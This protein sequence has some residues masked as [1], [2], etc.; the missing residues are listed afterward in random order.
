MLVVLLIAI[1]L[2]LIHFEG[3]VVTPS[4]HF[5]QAVRHLRYKVNK[6]RFLP[7]HLQLEMT[8]Y[9]YAPRT[10][11]STLSAPRLSANGCVFRGLVLFHITNNHQP[12]FPSPTEVIAHSKDFEK[13]PQPKP[14]I[15]PHLNLLVKFEHHAQVVVEEALFLRA[16]RTSLAN[17]I[18]SPEVYGWRAHENIVFIYMKLIQG[19]TLRERWDTLTTAQKTA[20]TD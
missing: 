1:A 17:K 10:R 12:V 20:I 4:N 14:V 13:H 18:P 9:Q 3:H 16:L 19:D 6:A 8:V 7:H 5:N 2:I 11:F 15:F